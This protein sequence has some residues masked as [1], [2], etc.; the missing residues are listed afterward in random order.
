MRYKTRSE[1]EAITDT[2]ELLSYINECL[3]TTSFNKFLKDSNIPKGYIKNRLEGY[4][5]NNIAKQFIANT[6]QLQPDTTTNTDDIQVFHDIKNILEVMSLHMTSLCD[7]VSIIKGNMDQVESV[8]AAVNVKGN[9]SRSIYDIRPLKT[10]EDYVIRNMKTHKSILKR[11][12][13]LSLET[14]YNQQVV[15]SYLLDQVLSD[16]G[17]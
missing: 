16:Y 9:A 17:Y 8:P 12:K 10:S 2:Q 3:Q 13:A 11:L 15:L 1:L 14:G 4:S 5:Y 7:D 6:E